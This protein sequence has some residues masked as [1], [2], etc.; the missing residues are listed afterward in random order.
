MFSSLP[1][2]AA[3]V[4][5][6]SE[7][8]NSTVGKLFPEPLPAVKTKVTTYD[9]LLK[10]KAEAGANYPSNIRIEPPLQKTKLAS[11]TPEIRE[12]LKEY[13]KER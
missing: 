8:A 4:I 9:L 5:P 13:L 3:R 6:R 2:M 7:L 10:K 1:R 12:E 11:L